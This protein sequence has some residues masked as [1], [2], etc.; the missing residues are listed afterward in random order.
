MDSWEGGGGVLVW[1]GG[2]ASWEGGAQNDIHLSSFAM[3]VNSF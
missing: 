2:G 3:I 1:G